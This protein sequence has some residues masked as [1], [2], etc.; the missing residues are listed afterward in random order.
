MKER[1]RK[2]PNKR[3]EKCRGVHKSS[4]NIH[5]IQF[6]RDHH[7]LKG[8]NIDAESN[9]VKLPICV[10]NQLHRIIDNS[11]YKDDLT[12]RVYFANMAVNQELDLIPEN[13]YRTNPTNKTKK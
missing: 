11:I 12:T 7:R 5:H 10:H 13:F 9:K 3:K 2:T 1:Y 4:E 6:K 8:F